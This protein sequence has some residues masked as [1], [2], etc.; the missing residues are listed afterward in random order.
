MERV[1]SFAGLCFFIGCSYLLSKDRK[2]INW[3]TVIAGITLQ[4][5]FGVFVLK[6]SLG[7]VL[8]D[9]ARGIFAEILNYTNEGSKFVFGSLADSKKL[10]LIHI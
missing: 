1:I 9:G 7:H 6:T 2:N 3:K 4:F 10:S 5:L 8:F